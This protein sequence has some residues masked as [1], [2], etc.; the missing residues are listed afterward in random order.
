MLVTTQ[1]EGA[2]YAVHGQLVTQAHLWSHCCALVQSY[3]IIWC[4]RLI[5]LDPRARIAQLQFVQ[6]HAVPAS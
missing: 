6:R 3:I 5:A 1:T 2:C 4:F